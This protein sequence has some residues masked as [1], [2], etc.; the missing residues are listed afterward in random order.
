ML[1]KLPIVM[2]D[3]NANNLES[4]KYEVSSEGNQRKLIVKMPRLTDTGRF[5][6]WKG[7]NSY[8]EAVVTF[9]NE[10]GK[11]QKYLDDAEEAAR[12]AAEDASRALN[13]AEENEIF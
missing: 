12:K 1:L 11:S 4:G 13:L 8:T 10:D 2:K 7:T 9:R 3:M 5:S 6:C